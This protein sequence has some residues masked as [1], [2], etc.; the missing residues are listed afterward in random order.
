METIVKLETPETDLPDVNSNLP[1]QTVPADQDGDVLAGQQEGGAAV[2]AN[3]TDTP[4]EYLS[5]IY[6]AMDEDGDISAL[7]VEN[8]NIYNA[9]RKMLTIA[10]TE[11]TSEDGDDT[12]D[13]NANTPE[14]IVGEAIEAPAPPEAPTDINPTVETQGNTMTPVVKLRPDEKVSVAAAPPEAQKIDRYAVPPR[15][16]SNSAKPVGSDDAFTAS[17]IHNF[18]K[19][20]VR[21]RYKGR[22]KEA[23]ALESRIFRAVKEGRVTA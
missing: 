10:V 16:V 4:S 13:D 21:G 3:D 2:D 22:E 18:Y 23:D 8:P 5:N 14:V 9:V 19:D 6:Q 11:L 17:E 12:D 1:T 15:A 20:V 7:R